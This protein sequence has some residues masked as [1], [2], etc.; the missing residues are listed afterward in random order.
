MDKTIKGLA[1]QPGTLNYSRVAFRAYGCG[2]ILVQHI[3]RINVLQAGLE[4]Y[5][6][7]ALKSRGGGWSNMKHFMRGVKSRD[8]PGHERVGLSDKFGYFA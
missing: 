4:P 2:A 6:S 7:G 8:M 1:C 3:V 5:L